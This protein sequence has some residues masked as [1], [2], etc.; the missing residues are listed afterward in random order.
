MSARANIL[1]VTN[2]LLLGGRRS[3]PGAGS[4]SRW[5]FAA[6]TCLAAL[7]LG[8]LAAEESDA[9]ALL[10]SIPGTFTQAGHQYEF[11]LESVKGQTNTPRTFESGKLV[12]VKAKDWTSG[13]FPG[14]LWYLYEFTGDEKWKTTAVDYTA[15][16]E[17]IRN[18]AGS[19]DVGFILNCSFGNGYRLTH[20]PKYREVLNQGA[21]TLS[22]RFK[23]EVGLI[24]SWDHGDWKYPVII[25]NMMN[26]EL[27]TWSAR[28]ANEP[29]LRDI[30]IQHAD[31][32]LKNHFRPDG[33]CWHVI[34]YDP[35]NGAM[36]KKQTHQGAAD[37]SSWARGQAW[38]LYGYT[39]MYRETRKAEYL[40]QAEKVARFLMNHPR[41]PEDKVPY[42]D[43]DAPNIPNA[44]RDASAAAVMSSGLIELSN[45]VQPEFGRQC[46]QLA[47]QQLLSLSSPAYLAKPGENGGFL[48][49]HC[50]GNLPK[51]SEVDAPLNYA[52]YYFLEAL[53]RY[54]ARIISYD[55]GDA[56]PSVAGK[57]AQT[58][59]TGKASDVTPLSLPGSEPFVFRKAGTNELRLH[60]VKP[61]GWSKENRRPC[62][63]S[64]FGG[65][66]V[67]GSPESSIRWSKWAASQGIVGIAPDY[68]TRTRFGGT[69]EDCVSDGRAAVRWIEEHAEEL[70]ID[71]KKII[72]MGGSAGGHVAAWTA[73]PSPGPGKDDPA[74]G[75]IPAALV[76]LNPVT[77][78]KPSGYGG[79]K[80]FGGDAARA[81]ACSVPDQMPAKM[82]PTIV[83]HATAD[84]TVPYANS[85]SFRD[86]LL[87]NGSRCE[88][89]TFEGLGH[90][91]NSSKFG[92]AGKAA[93][94]KTHDAVAEFLAGLGLI[95]GGPT[96]APK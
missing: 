75:V 17:D 62:F 55:A 6:V 21:R 8:T 35:A 86:K 45:F 66:W 40:T 56:T 34:E 23:P 78:T 5:F 4:W 63:V 2:R 46:I 47:R 76:L 70:G 24:R 58:N 80:R 84:K 22:A 88:L 44:P 68:R 71:P 64:F 51:K 69:P 29:R 72:S 87:T 18:H 20:D 95:E 1:S 92:E 31:N 85:V 28:E 65:G 33:S 38:A 61:A 11:L 16:L 59:S 3:L 48:L 82:P 12:T 60:V 39:M 49:R 73:I 37:D 15:R 42:W 25:D 9:D 93:D 94:K 53:L 67:S 89:V 19:H 83:F 96:L 77:D 30:A 13:F 90:S 52:D 50:V 10:T 54:R 26:L 32:T 79:P 41:L 14:S 91:Y 36:V 7:P 81:L 74:P 27:L 57:G 43:F